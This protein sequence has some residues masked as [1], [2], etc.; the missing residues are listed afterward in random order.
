MNGMPRRGTFFSLPNQSNAAR[1]FD[2]W[3]ASVFAFAPT[4]AWCR[5]PT[6][7]RVAIRRAGMVSTGL[8]N[9]LAICRSEQSQCERVRA[10]RS[11]AL[12]M[13]FAASAKEGS[14]RRGAVIG[15]SSLVSVMCLG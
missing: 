9:A 10:G 14:S 7:K 3:L 6:A 4:R 5:R 12:S 1:T 15:T 11:A 2:L 13:A 8:S